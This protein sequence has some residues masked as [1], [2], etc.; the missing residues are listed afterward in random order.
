MSK[1]KN[2]WN[3]RRANAWI[4][5]ELVII[6]I[7]SWI[8]IDPVAVAISDAS[9]P[10]GYD[11]DRLLVAEIATLDPLAD[12]YDPARDSV[13]VNREDIRTLMMKVR[14]HPAVEAATNDF[15]FDLP[16]SI[17]NSLDSPRS[18]NVAVDTVV[19]L[20][21]VFLYPRGEDYFQTMG[22]KSS[23][24]S[25]SAE[26]LSDMENYGLDR[27]IITREMGEIY[28]P[29]ENAV[30]KKFVRKVEENGDTAYA[31]VVGVVD[32]IRHQRP[33]RSYCAIFKCGDRLLS[34]E[35]LHFMHV[36]IRLKDNR[37]IDEQCREIAEW[38]AR[39]MSV[40]NFFLRDIDTYE[41]YLEK[42]DI[43]LGIPNQLKIGYILAGFFLVNLVLGMVGT[44]WLQ[45]RKRM[46]EM[47]I[48]RAFGARRGDI[49]ARLVGENVILAT[50]ASLAGFLL[51]W[52]YAL[53]NGVD[54]GYINN[55]GINVV[56]NWVGNF[57]EHFLIVSAIVYVL[58]IICVVAGTLVPALNISRV[59]IVDA[60]RSKE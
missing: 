12:G 23:S 26:E 54:T 17:S 20:S 43:Q 40:G 28:W 55:G 46:A 19:G 57:G 60:L 50:V 27:L 42:T 11:T 15:G 48:R 49:A 29:G 37:N 31:T 10:M 25:A 2:I 35:P 9:M 6:S 16:G 14:N 44:F 24:G 1:I 59:E 32:G 36:V 45:T 7:V 5:M 13:D 39:E 51:Y 41:A 38:G 33:Y 18:G 56:D 47:G 30:G 4:F 8:I 21:N 53:R 22:I 52:Q 3:N 34:D 58:I